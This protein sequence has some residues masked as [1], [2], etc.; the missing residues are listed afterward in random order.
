M[1]GYDA[2]DVPAS[3]K[4]RTYRLNLPDADWFVEA[5]VTALTELGDYANWTINGTADVDYCVRSGLAI[6]QSLQRSVELVGMV[7][8]YA[9]QILPFGCLWCD[10]SQV[11]QQDYPDLYTLLGNT[12]GSADTGMFRLP[13]MRGR[14]AIGTGTGSGLTNRDLADTT[15]TETHQLTTSEIPSHGHS[16]T[17][18]QHTT[19]N[20]LTFLALT[21]EEP[22]LMPN[23]IPALT[24]S[25]SANITSTGGDGAHN[26]MQPSLALN[27]VIVAVA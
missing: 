14:A 8:P 11:S 20:S 13:D 10:G 18:H 23:P 6:S 26:N 7:F 2:Y 27:F 17:G 19:G 5:L 25:A 9:G 15:G 1:E 3:G 21:G 12:F 24:G 16:D 4:F 22:V